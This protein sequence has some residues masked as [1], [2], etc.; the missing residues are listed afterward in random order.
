RVGRR[1]GQPWAMLQNPCGVR[2]VTLPGSAAGSSRPGTPNPDRRLSL[3]ES[4]AAFAERKTTREKLFY[5]RSR[6]REASCPDGMRRLNFIRA[7]LRF[8]E[9][10]RQTNPGAHTPGSPVVS[11]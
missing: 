8:L 7:K 9:L 11:S 2:A 4:C 3:R 10:P 5:V 1:A 6:T